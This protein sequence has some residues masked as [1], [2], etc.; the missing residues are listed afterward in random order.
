MN[1]RISLNTYH[2]RR[3]AMSM[4]IFTANNLA[5]AAGV[6]NQTAQD[7]LSALREQDPQLLAVEKLPALKPGR[8]VHRYTLTSKGLA[9]L[10]TANTPFNREM[11]EEALRT[12]PALQTKPAIAEPQRVSWTE[13][14]EEWLENRLPEFQ[15][16]VQQ[17]ASGLLIKAGQAA[18]ARVGEQIVPAYTS[19]IWTSQDVNHAL[20]D[21]FNSRQ[22]ER[23]A[24]RGWTAFAYKSEKYE[25]IEFRA[26]LAEGLPVL[27]LR[28]LPKEVPSL[29][30]VNLPQL[31]AALSSMKTG[32]LLVTG[33]AGSGKSGAIA[34][35]IGNINANRTQHITTIDEPIRYYHSNRQSFIEQRQIAVDTPDFSPAIEQALAA[36]SNVVAV[37]SVPDRESFSTILAA[38]SRALVFCR[39]PSPSPA[40]AIRKLLGL[41]P[42][43]EQKEARARLAQQLSGVIS[44][45]ALP[46]IS[47]SGV[48]AATEVLAWQPEAREA[49]VNPEKTAFLV[50]ELNKANGEIA[51]MAESIHA[52][53]LK[54]LISHQTAQRCDSLEQSLAISDNVH[55][56]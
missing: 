31:A 15:S 42:Q 53:R 7:F 35:M 30:D 19:H 13:R 56:R 4:G 26:Q 2:L 54:G 46:H 10:A 25:P 37:S 18:V 50:E 47:G 32:L 48:V 44:V 39:V 14:I 20:Q 55:I 41:V 1:E 5:S 38:A 23:L 51:T 27:E 29:E 22:H 36:R 8:R 24:Q 49:I 21:V 33:V 12:D 40:E 3:H 43:A 9:H 16:L 45:V 52:L 6:T 11:N 34:A 28:F 17:G